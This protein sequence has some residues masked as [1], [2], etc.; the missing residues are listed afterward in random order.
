VSRTNP[1]TNVMTGSQNG[2]LRTI[3]VTSRIRFQRG[4]GAADTSAPSSEGNIAAAIAPLPDGQ[5]DGRPLISDSGLDLTARLGETSSSIIFW[6]KG[7]QSWFDEASPF[8]NEPTV[9]RKPD[10]AS[11]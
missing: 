10:P 9:G 4:V 7:G 11:T 6:K 2:E 8:L 3:Q 1:I 5:C